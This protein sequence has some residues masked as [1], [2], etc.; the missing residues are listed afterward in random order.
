MFYKLPT[1]R[2]MKTKQKLKRLIILKAVDKNES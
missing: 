1:K 2:C